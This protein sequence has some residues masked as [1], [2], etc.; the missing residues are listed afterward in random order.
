MATQLLRHKSD[1]KQLRIKFELYIITT[2][3]ASFIDIIKVILYYDAVII[4]KWC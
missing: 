3:R 2:T 1:L 4:N